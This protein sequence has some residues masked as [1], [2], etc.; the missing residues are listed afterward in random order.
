[1]ELKHKSNQ[2]CLDTSKDKKFAEGLIIIECNRS[3]TQMW[4]LEAI[5]WK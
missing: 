3:K 1:M 2:R 4:K 5:P